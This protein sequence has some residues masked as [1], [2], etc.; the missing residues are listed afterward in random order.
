VTSVLAI[1][2]MCLAVLLGAGLLSVGWNPFE[3][4]SAPYFVLISGVL[5]LRLLVPVD[6]S[7]WVNLVR[8]L[9]LVIPAA[10]F[11]FL[12]RGL[13]NARGDVAIANAER[14]IDLERRLGMFHEI[15]LQN[16]ISG[17]QLAINIVNWIYIWGHWPLITVIVLWLVLYHRD[18]FPLYRNAFLISGLMGMVVFA[19]YPVAPPRLMPDLAIIDTVTQHSRSYRVLQPPALT[20]P[21]AAMPSLHFGWNL[22]MGIAVARQ[23]RTRLLKGFGVLMPVLMCSAIVLTG[24][25]YI[26]DGIVGGAFVGIALM[27]AVMLPRLREQLFPQQREPATVPVVRR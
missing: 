5:L 12:V 20:N 6:G 13:V 23:A 7:R 22:L 11:Y 21:F 27:A 15:Q 19:L 2:H 26:L 17:S 25:H 3:W 8:E 18:A 10:I 1:A 9:L 24:N 16:L 4:A 14:I